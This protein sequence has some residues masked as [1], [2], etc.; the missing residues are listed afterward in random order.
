MRTTSRDSTH[1]D[2][3]H[4]SETENVKSSTI[5]L[6]SYIKAIH[7]EGAVPLGVALF[8][9][10]NNDARRLY[11]LYTH[12]TYTL[13]HTHTHKHTHIYTNEDGYFPYCRCLLLLVS[14]GLRVNQTIILVDVNAKTYLSV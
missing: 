14:E 2:H 4:L 13:T 8:I 5:N 3:P 1:K 12:I 7:A 6:D 9:N 10:N 11:S